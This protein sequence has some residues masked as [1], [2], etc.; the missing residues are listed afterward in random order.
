M[1]IIAIMLCE[2]H[3]SICLLFSSN[4][5]VKKTG[6]LNEAIS[7]EEGNVISKQFDSAQKWLRVTTWCEK[8]VL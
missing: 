5:I 8:N 3:E 6:L 1:Y 2:R 7:I 4:G